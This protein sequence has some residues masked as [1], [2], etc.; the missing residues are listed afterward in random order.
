MSLRLLLRLSKQIFWYWSY[1]ASLVFC[2]NC[3]KIGVN[4]SEPESIKE[5]HHQC[6]SL[7]KWP[8]HQCLSNQKAVLVGGLSQ[9]HEY[10]L[11][12]PCDIIN[13][14]LSSKNISF[15]LDCFS[16]LFQI[17]R[18][19]KYHHWF[20]DALAWSDYFFLNCGHLLF[21]VI[22]YDNVLIKQI[23]LITE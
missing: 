10:L 7:I 1:L 23:T 20:E 21:T 5:W 17:Q 12:P 6:V 14:C 2:K 15:H 19:A 3:R 22:F 16:Q 9:P 4:T 13:F 8:H 18:L 11:K